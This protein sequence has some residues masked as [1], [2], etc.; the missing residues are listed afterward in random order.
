MSLI[1]LE[2]VSKEYALGDNKLLA[3]NNVSL[4]MDVGEFAAVWGPSGSGKSTLLNIIGLLDGVS[5]G[6]V[7]MDGQDTGLLKEKALTDLRYRMLGFVFQNFNLVP[8][9][10]A[11]ENVMLPLQMRG[12]PDASSR[13]RAMA[14]L[15]AVGLGRF[16]AS[17]PDKMSGGQR[18][19][20]AIARALVTRPKLVLAD[21]P[22]ANLDSNTSQVIIDLMREL[23]RTQG[24]TFLFSTH[25]TQ[26]LD[27]VH[28]HIHLRDGCVVDDCRHEIRPVVAGVAPAAREPKI[29]VAEA[30]HP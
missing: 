17:R 1:T 6:R 5:A 3:L 14:L 7:V 22:T 27:N 29:A 21:E 30:S 11:L 18:Q 20:V 10:S 23:N 16:I 28:R 19:R 25:D 13:Q 2:H 9:L 12:E 4:Q 8:V 26:L 24:V 15:E